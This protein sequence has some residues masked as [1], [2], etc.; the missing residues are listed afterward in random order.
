M[1]LC[2]YEDGK[3]IEAGDIVFINEKQYNVTGALD[4]QNFSVALDIS[5]EEV[6]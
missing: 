6:I 3:D 1:I 5:L 4:I 2:L